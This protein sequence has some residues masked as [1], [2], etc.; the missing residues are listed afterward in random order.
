MG[1]HQGGETTETLTSVAERSAPDAQTRGSGGIA[2]HFKSMTPG[3]RAKGAGGD[4]PGVGPRELCEI[5]R[6]GGASAN[7]RWRAR[8]AIR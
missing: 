7:D 4:D 2:L 6:S 1:Q 8:N 5:R 3:R